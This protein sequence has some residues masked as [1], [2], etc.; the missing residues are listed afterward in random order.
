MNQ[1]TLTEAA[2]FLMSRDNFMILTHRN[3]DGDTLGSA[4]A[5][6]LA[7][8]AMGKTAALLDNPQVTRVYAPE[9]A[10]LTASR[11]DGSFT[12]IAVDCASFGLLQKNAELTEV[13]LSLVIDHH[14]EHS[15]YS[16]KSLVFP[17]KSSCG[18]IILDLLHAL[19]LDITPEIARLLYIAVSTDTGCFR[20]KN[21]NADTLSAAAELVRVGVPNGDINHKLFRVKRMSRLKLESE[22]IAGL[23]LLRGGQLVIAVI[24]QEMLK[25]SGADE[26]D[27]DDITNIALQPE[28]AEMSVTL[29]EERDGTTRV[30]VRTVLYANANKVC[31]ELGG[32]G[33]GRAA[34]VTLDTGIAESRERMLSAIGKWWGTE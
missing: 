31:I 17:H 18:E 7:L 5:L 10:G 16:E 25:R 22:I 4:G 9:I 1:I 20:Y 21:T 27:L 3:P 8:R 11:F 19:R 28:G 14:R 30:S 6:C 33:H 32:G 15:P 26:S 29:R 23:E 13:Q 24:T 12:A 34:G 2:E